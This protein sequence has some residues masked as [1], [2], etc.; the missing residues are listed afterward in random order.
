KLPDVAVGPHP[1]WA[2]LCLRLVF[3]HET[4][5]AIDVADDDLAP[6]GFHADRR[7]FGQRAG[8][9]RR[10]HRKARRDVALLDR[11]LETAEAGLLSTDPM[12][13]RGDAPRRRPSLVLL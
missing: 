4:Q 3:V 7:Q 12:Q 6:F 10:R 2:A 11:E 9:R 13:E 8:E 1:A 5:Q